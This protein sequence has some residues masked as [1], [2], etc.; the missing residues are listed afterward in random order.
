MKKF[1]FGPAGS[2]KTVRGVEHL[3]NLI[4]ETSNGI[5][6]YVPQRTLAAPYHD[7]VGRVPGIVPDI[8][9]IG[10]LSLEITESEERKIPLLGSIPILGYLFRYTSESVRESEVVIFVTPRII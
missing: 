1:L 5:L 2:G 9:T 8:L 7:L 4:Q 6:V 3:G 10:G